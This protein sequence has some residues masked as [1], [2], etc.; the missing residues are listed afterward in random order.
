MFN[1]ERYQLLANRNFEQY[2]FILHEAGIPP[3]HT[4]T[5]VLENLSQEIKSKLYL[6]HIAIKDLPSEVSG[7]S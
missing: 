4:P 3:I 6:Y 2:D 1:K 7:L 5:P